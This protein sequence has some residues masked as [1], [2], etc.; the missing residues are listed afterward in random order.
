MAPIAADTKITHTRKPCG[1]SK[2]NKNHSTSNKKAVPRSECQ[3]VNCLFFIP[4]LYSAIFTVGESAQRCA[5]GAYQYMHVA[6]IV[7]AVNIALGF[8]H[9]RAHETDSYLV[10]RL[11]LEKKKK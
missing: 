6:A 8:T 3:S 5:G 9:L 4:L 1:A 10:C 7:G 2:Y 11:L